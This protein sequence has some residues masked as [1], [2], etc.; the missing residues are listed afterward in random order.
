MIL[1]NPFVLGWWLFPKG[2]TPPW[3]S[4]LCHCLSNLTVPTWRVSFHV[5][6]IV[7]VPVTLLHGWRGPCRCPF[8]ASWVSNHLL[9]AEVVPLPSAPALVKQG[10]PVP[11]ELGV[12]HLRW[13]SW[14]QGRRIYC[15]FLIMSKEALRVSISCFL[16]TWGAARLLSLVVLVLFFVFL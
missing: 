10:S 14:R 1:C 4:H 3:L 13:G 9:C 7:H 11:E 12:H 16:L 2:R 6:W 5:F 15:D 8:T